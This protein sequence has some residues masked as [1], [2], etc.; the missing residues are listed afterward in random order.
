[1]FRIPV[2]ETT[3]QALTEALKLEVEYLK[4]LRR[5]R[6]AEDVGYVMTESTS[7]SSPT[8]EEKSKVRVKRFTCKGESIRRGV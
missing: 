6:E 7:S 3:M 8:G 4:E 1:M 5:E 2:D